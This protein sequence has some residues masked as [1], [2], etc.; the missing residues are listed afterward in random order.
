MDS[1]I[2]MQLLTMQAGATRQSAAVSMIRKAAEAEQ[3][4]VTMIDD[5]M[6]NAPPPPTAGT[7]LV[8]DKRA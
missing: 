5:G 7:G 6:K 3:A 2:T 8:V 1:D 4:V